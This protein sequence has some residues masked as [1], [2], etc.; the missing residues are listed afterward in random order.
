MRILLLSITVV[1]LG[2]AA[3]AEGYCSLIVKVV[4]PSGNEVSAPID[5]EERS[6]RLIEKQESDYEVGGIRFCDLGLSMVT[7]TVGFPGCNQVIVRNVPLTWGE[8]REVYVIYDRQPCLSPDVIP[9]TC[10]FLFRFEDLQYDPIQKVLF[11]MQEPRKRTVE[12]DEFGRVSVTLPFD[13]ELLGTASADGYNPI[14]L[15]LPCTV[16]NGRMEQRFRMKR[17]H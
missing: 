12:A 2:P 17:T 8:T 6:G 11:K 7:V 5:V 16:P 10:R 1:M 9:Q 14:E 15:R 13:R 4:N 3:Y